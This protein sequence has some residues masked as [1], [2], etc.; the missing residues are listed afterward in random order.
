MSERAPSG[1]ILLM[2][3]LLIA[4]GFLGLSTAAAL[5]LLRLL[6]VRLR[7]WEQITVSVALGSLLSSWL[8]FVT[9]Y[10]FS[11]TT[12]TWI[13]T[14]LLLA[15]ILLTRLPLAARR[16]LEAQN[17]HAYLQKA[18]LKLFWA[19]LTAFLALL[20]S[21]TYLMANPAQWTSNGGI[22]SDLALH[23]SLASFF[24]EQ[25]VQNLV[26]PIFPTVKLAYPF[27]ADL[28]SAQLH[29]L[30]V[31]W[32]FAMGV[33]TFALLASSVGLLV[34]IGNRFL[35]RYRSGLI[36][37]LLV[38]CSGVALGTLAYLQDALTTTPQQLV[39]Y[40]HLAITQPG[41]GQEF[42][43]FLTSHLLPQR[44]YLMG[45]AVVLSVLLMLTAYLLR[46]HKKAATTWAVPLVI[47]VIG[48]LLPFAH[49]HSFFVLG[50]FL[51]ILAG[52]IS[53]H[54]QELAVEWIAALGLMALIAAPQLN[55]QFTSTY[56]QSFSHWA[57]GWL[58]PDGTS[59][60]VFW[61]IN[62]GVLIPLIVYAIWKWRPPA[63][64]RMLTTSL[65]ITSLGIFIAIN[66]YIFQ[67][68]GWDN[69][70]FLTYAYVFATLPVAWLLNKW[71]E[72]GSWRA[73]LTW[74]LLLIITFPGMTA[75]YLAF[76]DQYPF[77][78]TEDR[79]FASYVTQHTDRSSVILTSSYHHNPVPILTGRL[80]LMGYPGWLGSYG[81]DFHV[82]EADVA[83]MRQGGPNAAKLIQQY[84]VTH[85]AVSDLEAIQEHLDLSHLAEHYPEIYTSGGWH[86][87]EVK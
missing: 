6:P 62:L 50:A 81:I 75:I 29:Y 86:L 78:T 66:V 46:E 28:Q 42:A 35:G 8:T 38:T 64:L 11:Q 7:P 76:H 79:T 72:R 47:G 69:M 83:T 53:W 56:T 14:G 82:V 55:W 43:N 5:G 73:V 15:T 19:F 70:K 44:S 3:Q 41:N 37:A 71:L 17:A 80:I 10:G 33:P 1:M 26:F 63:H 25:G 68:S 32:P 18:H 61:F 36:W 30:G 85:I 77:L 51:T 21:S 58:T 12:G 84:G 60:L 20:V 67:P 34:Q 23:M 87:Y 27:L 48:G 49:V 4:F 9:W 52:L 2:Y 13:T 31:D 22:W 74:I 16:V 45:F 40:S 59:P 57:F 39:D 24:S 54:R 65:L